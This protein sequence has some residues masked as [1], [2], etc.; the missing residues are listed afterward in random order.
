MRAKR[1]ASKYFVV[2]AG[3]NVDY[4]TSSGLRI[5]CGLLLRERTFRMNVPN[6]EL[7]DPVR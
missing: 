5:S 4:L 1:V 6:S 7:A 2:R 3:L